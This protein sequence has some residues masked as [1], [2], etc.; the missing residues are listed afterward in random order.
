MGSDYAAVDAV[1]A[2]PQTG[3][4]S[5]RVAG[6]VRPF[7]PLECKEGAAACLASRV[8][9]GAGR[10]RKHELIPWSL[11]LGRGLAPPN[12]GETGGLRFA[13]PPT[14]AYQSWEHAMNLKQGPL[15]GL[16]V[17]EIAGLG[18]GPFCGMLLADLGADVVLV[19]R[20]EQAAD[21]MDFGPLAIYK[22]GKR[23]VAADLKTPEGVGT[24][25]DLVEHSCALIEGMR[26]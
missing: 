19:E 12:R 3:G 23:S 1:L 6:S 13:Y 2:P 18:P 7:A 17:L 22:R 10:A 9:L 25:L 24:V 26:P 4:M 16:R 21:E 14:I 11:H 20:G 15:S 8:D 5:G